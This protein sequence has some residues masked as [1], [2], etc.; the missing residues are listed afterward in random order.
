MLKA[1]CWGWGWCR[2][3]KLQ[4]ATIHHKLSMRSLN[5]YCV[6]MSNVLY[7][8]IH[9][10]F[11]VG[12]VSTWVSDGKKTR[13]GS[14]GGG[15]VKCRAAARICPLFVRRVFVPLY[16]SNNPGLWSAFSAATSDTR[17][18]EQCIVRCRSF[19]AALQLMF[20]HLMLFPGFYHPQCSYKYQKIW[21]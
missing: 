17:T 6:D 2:A 7:K 4:A 5:K 12:M 11:P 8:Y 18:C 21:L 13:L 10:Y 16:Y 19:Y 3:G 9:T 15:W 1:R 14:D 20:H